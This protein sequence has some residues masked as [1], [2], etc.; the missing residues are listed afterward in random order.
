MR[1]LILRKY[2]LFYIIIS[3]AQATCQTKSRSPTSTAHSTGVCNPTETPQN[4]PAEMK[5]F[6]ITKVFDV[7]AEVDF[8]QT[9]RKTRPTKP[10]KKKKGC[11]CFC[12]T[13]KTVIHIQ[14]TTSMLMVG[15]VSAILTIF[16]NLPT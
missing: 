16:N 10:K 12:Q 5:S 9:F 1:A 4:H 8:W 2:T 13:A 11:N 14:I 7:M 15:V 3:R 6:L